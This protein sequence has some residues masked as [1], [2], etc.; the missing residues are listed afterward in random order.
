MKLKTNI[1]DAWYRYEEPIKGY[2]LSL[3]DV[4]N[5]GSLAFVVLVL[6]ISWSGTKA[7]QTNY[8]LQQQVA[9]LQ[10]QNEVKKLQNETQ[11][12]E[13]NYYT[14]SQ[15]RELAARQNFGLAAPGE[16]VL[17]VSKEAALA[18][19]AAAPKDEGKTLPAKKKP[20]YQENFEAWIDFFF[21][22]T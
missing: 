9:R 4:R 11:K 1:V 14:T 13:N 15:Y 10:Q 6:L 2:I 8:G 5:V 7:I 16:T 20:F 12:L 18:N 19:T 3:R 21:H 22:R 17:L